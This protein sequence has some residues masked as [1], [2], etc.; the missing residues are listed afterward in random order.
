MKTSLPIIASLR[1]LRQQ[2][3]WNRTEAAKRLCITPRALRSWETGDRQPKPIVLKAIEQFV[4]EN[5]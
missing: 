5:Q 3:R 2:K 4:A 1:Y